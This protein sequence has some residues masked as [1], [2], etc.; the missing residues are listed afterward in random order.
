MRVR[1]SSFAAATFLLPW[2]S[3]PVLAAQQVTMSWSLPSPLT[4]STSVAGTPDAQTSTV[5]PGV[6]TSAQ[7]AGAESATARI[8]TTVTQTPLQC[9]LEIQHRLD[10]ATSGVPAAA[11]NADT[12]VLLQFTALAPESVVLQISSA[13]VASAGA[14]APSLRVDVDD[15]GT[16]DWQSSPSTPS[17]SIVRQ[18]DPTPTLVRVRATSSLPITGSMQ[19]T[20]AASIAPV[21]A[22]QIDITSIG[23]SSQHL[24][25]LRAFGGGIEVGTFGPPPTGPILLVF[26]LGLAPVIL[27]SPLPLPCLLLPTIDIVALIPSPNTYSL[28]LPPSVRPVTFHTQAVPIT[29]L[30]FESTGSYRVIAN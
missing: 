24:Y 7:T 26:G 3:L 1:R 17:L 23:C 16:I 9:A 28:P 21:H 19:A 10:V 11:A 4:A 12:D 22:T 13:L 20:L 5:L 27:P 18:L 29:G 6:L 14:P 15:D 2:L 8:T 25:A 30:G